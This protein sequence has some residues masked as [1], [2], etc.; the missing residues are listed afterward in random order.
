MNDPY[1]LIDQALKMYPEIECARVLFSGGNDSLTT[2]HLAMQHPFVKEHGVIWHINTG[3]GIKETNQFAKETAAKY[4]W[5]FEEWKAVEHVN[6]KGKPDPQRYD[7]LVLKHGFPGPAQHSK[8]YQRL[9]ERQLARGIRNLK[10]GRGKKAKKVMLISGIRQQESKRR[11]GWA[12]AIHRDGSWV[13]VNICFNWSKADCTSYHKSNGIECNEVSKLICMSGECTCGAF[14][15]PGEFDL[16]ATCFPEWGDRIIKLQKEVMKKFPW[17]WEQAPPQWWLKEQRGQMRLP[18]IS[19]I[20]DEPMLP[21]CTSCTY[22]KTGADAYLGKNPVEYSVKTT[23][24]TKYVQ[25]YTLD[26]DL[27]LE[28]F[29]EEYPSLEVQGIEMRI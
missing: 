24:G 9:K 4:G 25:Y 18:G 19:L 7:D 16:I 2:A 10:L 27:V 23:K 1:A 6:S 20:E 5:K 12:E 14:A 3:I 15:K 13:W 26:F 8:M 28:Q 22:K 21:M 17:K 11:M 29:K